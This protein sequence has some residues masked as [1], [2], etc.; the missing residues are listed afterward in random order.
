MAMAS[1]SV[2]LVQRKPGVDLSASG[3][4]GFNFQ[5]ATG[6]GRPLFH[7]YHTEAGT[8]DSLCTDGSHIKSNAVVAYLKMKLATF[9][10]QFH[11]DVFRPG[12]AHHI[13]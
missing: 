3:Y 2:C 9:C 12:V 11:A 13:G 1:G 8:T 6:Q 10:A 5:S 4:H 7:A